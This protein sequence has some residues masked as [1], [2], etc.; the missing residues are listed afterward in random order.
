MKKLVFINLFIC[1]TSGLIAQRYKTAVGVRVSIA[2]GLTIKHKID[3][4]TAI[5]GTVATRWG[6]FLITGLYEFTKSF[7]EPGLNWYYGI[8]GHIAHWNSKKSEFPSW[9]DTGHDGAYTGSFP[10]PR[11]FASPS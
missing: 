5:E 7:N 2:M 10:L 4:Y 9:W 3:K 11:T 8:G 6:G 1:F